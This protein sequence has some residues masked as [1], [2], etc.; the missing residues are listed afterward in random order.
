MWRPRTGRRQGEARRHAA[1]ARSRARLRCAGW[2]H[3]ASQHEFFTRELAFVLPAV[4]ASTRRV[5]RYRGATRVT[6]TRRRAGPSSIACKSSRWRPRRAP[7]AAR[8]MADRPGALCAARYRH[9]RPLSLG[10]RARCA[11]GLHRRRVR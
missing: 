10:R 6:A 4:S 8:A 2:R 7:A 1:R 5:S 3:E 11:F 9:A